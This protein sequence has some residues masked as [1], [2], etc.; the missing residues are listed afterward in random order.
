MSANSLE[1]RVTELEEEVAHLKKRLAEGAKVKDWRRTV[2]MFEGDATM[3][4]IDRL[5]LKVREDDPRKARQKQRKR[6]A[7]ES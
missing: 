7:I 5:T 1:R 6:K 3:E 4:E 2:G